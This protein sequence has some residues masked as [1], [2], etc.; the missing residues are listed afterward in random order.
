MIRVTVPATTANL[1][2]GFDTLGLALN[3]YN[4]FSFEEIE[5]GLEILGVPE[6]YNNEDNLIYRSM[7]KTFK[8]IGYKKKGIRITV[9]ASIPV[10]RGLGS[11]ASCIVGGVVGANALANG[12]LSKEDILKIAT[13][14]EGHPD[15]VAPAIFGGLVISLIDGDNILYNKLN[16]EEKFKFIALIPE[17]SLS[18]EKARSVLPSNVKYKDAVD[19]VGRVSILLSALSNG[20]LDLLKYALK[21]K[22][23][24]PYRGRLIKDYFNII[25]KCKELGSLGTYLSGAGPTIISLRENEDVRFNES[26]NKYLK[27]LDEKWNI[28]ELEIDIEG[29]KLL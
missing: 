5:S 27:S 20:R 21:D 12:K 29:V 18:T 19:N 17:F 22:L 24:Q 11:S 9:E 13:E 25:E 3:L 2:P 28:K 8:T 23:H 15:N 16:I 1:G 4:I 7:M 6:K 14:I 26:I 10:S